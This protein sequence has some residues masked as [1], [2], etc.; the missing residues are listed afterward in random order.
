MCEITDNHFHLDVYGLHLYVLQLEQDRLYV[1]VWSHES[2]LDEDV[3]YYRAYAFNQVDR[4]GVVIKAWSVFLN[5]WTKANDFSR[6]VM[7]MTAASF[8]LGREH[9][10]HVDPGTD[11]ELFSIAVALMEENVYD[12]L[13]ADISDAFY[14]W[15]LSVQIGYMEALGFQRLT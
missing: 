5:L 11:I 14:R 13:P 9:L 12:D 3:I 1:V 15:Q 7:G 10:L 6:T 8:G 4:A 2:D